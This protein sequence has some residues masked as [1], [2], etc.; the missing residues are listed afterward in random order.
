[1]ILLIALQEKRGVCLNVHY[2]IFN[3]GKSSC[4]EANLSAIIKSS[5]KIIGHFKNFAQYQ[6]L[7]FQLVSRDIKMKYRRSMLG[8]LWSV[9]NPLLTMAIMTVVFSRMFSRGIQSFPAY[10][11]IGNL[12]FAFMSGATG[13]AIPSIFGNAA[14]LK[15]MYVPKYIFTL[16]A[17]TTELVTMFF[18]LI[19]LFIVM[20]ATGVPFTWYFILNV[21]PI[22]E[23]YIFCIGLGLFLAQAAV[24]F[25]DVQYIWGIITT[26]WMYMTPIFYP[27][28]MLPDW[29]RGLIV[30]FNPMYYYIT[31]FRSFTLYGNIGQIPNIWRGAL[32]SVLMLLVGFFAFSR[33]KNKFILHI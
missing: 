7:F 1:M 14:L 2:D 9:L 32:V 13:R 15:K 4:A 6:H 3:D 20:L 31:I 26:A 24:F 23:L 10:L 28:E 22:V 21:I 27:I 5:M 18:S 33:S 12:L 16:S 19:A 17:V 29:L 11:L 8:Y 25:R 30:K